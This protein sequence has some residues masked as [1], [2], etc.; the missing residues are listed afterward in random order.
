MHKN[1][2]RIIIMTLLVVLFGTCKEESNSK[3]IASQQSHIQQYAKGFE[4][5]SYSEGVSRISVMSPWPGADRVFT[6]WLIPRETQP[7]DSIIQTADAIITIPVENYVATS[8][9]HIATLEALGVLDKLRGFPGTDYISSDQARSLIREG[10]IQELG[11]NEALNTEMTLAMRPDVV[12]GFAINARNAGYQ[13]LEEAGI[14]VIYNGDW[15]EHTPL[16]KAEWIRFFAPFFGL[17]KRAD[18]L[19]RDIVTNYEQAKAL[20]S[21]ATKQPKVLSGALYKDIWYT[22]GGKSWAAQLITDANGSYL[23]ANT[24]ATGSLSLSIE[25]VLARGT[26]ADVWIAPSQYVA[27][28]TM[29]QASPHYNK[30]DA[31]KADRVYTYA[32]R[33]GESGGLI[34]FETAP[35]R[36][37]LV[38]KDLIHIFHPAVLPDY[39]L[40]FFSPLE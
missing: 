37:D 1:P 25:E 11:A 12:F 21:K 19:F 34:Y 23:W 39:Q 4:I 36:P 15:I 31:L 7:A 6:Y 20:A 13:T 26:H 16:G 32:A 29:L 30:F 17:E 10:A 40:H 9:T 5:R 18:S 27:K 2:A 22:P 8:T 24:E 33:R 28:E 38:L 14:P 35:Q 3:I